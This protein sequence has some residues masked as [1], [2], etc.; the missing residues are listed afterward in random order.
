[1]IFC[2]DS[3]TKKTP[4]NQVRL[5][6]KMLK[7]PNPEVLDSCFPP[8][9]KL[10][11]SPKEVIFRFRINHRFISFFSPSPYFFLI[12]PVLEDKYHQ[13]ELFYKTAL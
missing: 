11:S 3:F 7:K 1:M 10:P 6:L 5:E 8:C 13:F 4:M 2:V 12:C 9:S